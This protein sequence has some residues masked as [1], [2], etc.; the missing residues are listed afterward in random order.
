MR[1]FKELKQ[2]IFESGEHTFGGG[3]GNSFYH[4][5]ARSA[6][7]DYGKGTF[8]LDKEEN[9]DRVNAFLNSFFNRTFSDYKPQLGVLKSKLNLIG[10]DFDYNKN[11]ELSKGPNS[12]ELK[13][14]GGTFGKSP[15]TPHDEFERTNGFPEGMSYNL[16]M[17]VGM[18]DSGL[19]NIDANISQAGS[20]DGDIEA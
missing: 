8:E 12:F 1:T 17:N 3:F 20:T 14:W 18:S 16:N 13:R 10:L 9:I 2:K 5:G 6:I 7:K 15:T 11:T 19:Y 4:D